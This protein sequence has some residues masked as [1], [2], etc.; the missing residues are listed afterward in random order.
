MT[1]LREGREK[2]HT[3]RHAGRYARRDVL[4]V[5][6][7]LCTCIIIDDYEYTLFSTVIS[8]VGDEY[9]FN[10]HGH[11]IV[12]NIFQ[13]QVAVIWPDKNVQVLQQQFERLIYTVGEQCVKFR[14]FRVTI[15]DY[16]VPR[17]E[18][19]TIYIFI[20]CYENEKCKYIIFFG[21]SS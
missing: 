3:L 8:R 1:I 2:C 15:I 18:M 11:H 7:D 21:N 14:I 12:R 5:Q 16:D 6:Q 13:L 9:S 20:T 4:S 19:Y 10:A 17:Y